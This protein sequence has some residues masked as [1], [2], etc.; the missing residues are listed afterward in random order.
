MVETWSTGVD[1]MALPPPCRRLRG[2]RPHDRPAPSGLPGVLG[3]DAGVARLLAPPARHAGSADLDPLGALP[4]VPA[5]PGAP[6]LVRR[7]LALGRGDL[8]RAGPGARGGGL[9]PPPDR[10]RPRP[11][12]DDRAGLA[13]AAPFGRRAPRPSAPGG[14]ARAGWS[15]FE[16]P[17]PALPRLA[18]A[19]N[20]L[21][22]RWG[23]R[24]GPADAWRVANL[25]AGGVLL[26]T[27]TGAPLAPE[28]A[29]AVMARTRSREV[30]DGP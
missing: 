18:A 19:G 7:V 28:R 13:P 16:L 1:P 27:N 8:D 14:G 20:A 3:T 23:R 29:S 4:L 24:H 11:A 30:P 21:A 10:G 15:G 25:V 6:A 5:H 12:R 9:R 26:A 2:V 22:G 17:V